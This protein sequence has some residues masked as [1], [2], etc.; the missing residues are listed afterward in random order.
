MRTVTILWKDNR[1]V[2][3]FWNGDI[4]DNVQKYE[5]MNTALRFAICTWLGV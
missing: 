2:V 3:E 4:L 1:F 5:G